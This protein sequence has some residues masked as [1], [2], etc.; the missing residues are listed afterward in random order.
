MF[1]VLTFDPLLHCLTWTEEEVN[2]ERCSSGPA[3]LR[4][5]LR[6]VH[7]CGPSVV[8]AAPGCFLPGNGPLKQTALLRLL[9]L[10]GCLLSE[11][12]LAASSCSSALLAASSPPRPPPP[13]SQH[14][15]G[16]GDR[17]SRTRTPWKRWCC[18]GPAGQ[19]GAQAWPLLQPQPS[20]PPQ[21]HR[22]Q[23]PGPGLCNTRQ[24]V[25]V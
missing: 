16:P 18:G 13:P 9:L 19:D 8:T 21:Q 12:D 6:L 14:A 24:C 23:E 1:Q 4:G 25:S 7:T 17:C 20:G 3:D 10:S 5:R 22:L 15:D 2:L 11:D